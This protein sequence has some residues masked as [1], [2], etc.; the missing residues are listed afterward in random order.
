[1]IKLSSI[2]AKIH[3]HNTWRNGKCE[4]A[5]TTATNEINRVGVLASDP[6]NSFMSVK[7]ITW[8]GSVVSYAFSSKEIIGVY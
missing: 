2:Q 6:Y 4:N 3:A 7:Y 1:M 5:G 8:D